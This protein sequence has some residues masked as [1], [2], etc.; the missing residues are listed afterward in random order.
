MKAM[1]IQKYLIEF[2]S[3]VITLVRRANDAVW[4]Q[5]REGGEQQCRERGG[6]SKDGGVTPLKVKQLYSHINSG[7][8]TL[9][10]RFRPSPEKI[11]SSASCY[12]VYNAKVSFCGD[13]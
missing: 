4:W 8:F 11:H 12:G 3:L 2:Q 1:F 13:E 10:A 5:R 6:S 7:L 9:K